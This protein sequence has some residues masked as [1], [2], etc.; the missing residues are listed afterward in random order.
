MVPFRYKLSKG[1]RFYLVNGSN[2]VVSKIPLNIFRVNK[3]TGRLLRLCDGEKTVGEIASSIAGVSEDSVF[4]ICEYFRTKGVLTFEPLEESEYKPYITVII[5]TRDRRDEIKE[6]L[7]YV[8]SQNYPADKI[9]VIVV[10]DGSIDDTLEVLKNYPCQV[11]THKESKG[12]AFCR[13]LGVKRAKGDIV[14]FLDSDCMADKDWLKELVPYFQWS[15]LGAVGGYVAGYFEK[16]SLDR[17]EEA[18]SSLN[19]GNRFLYGADDRS[20]F[21]VPSCNFLVRKKVFLETGGFTEGMKVGEDVDFC[22]RMRALGY[23]LLYAPLGSVKHKHRNNLYQMLKRRAEYG[24]SEAILYTSRSG[25]RKSFY[26]PAFAALTYF[27]LA[28]SIISYHVLPLLVLPGVVGLDIIRKLFRVKKL[29][30][31]IPIRKIAYSVLRSHFLFCYFISFHLVRYYMILIMILGIIFHPLWIFILFSLLLSS[32]VDY[33][34]KRLRLSYP[35]FLMYYT[36]EHSAYQL[37]VF[38]GCIKKRTFKPY[39]PA[40]L[41]KSYQI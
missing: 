8:F 13:N 17:Y 33:A 14:A 24:T 18:F 6:C 41:T 26:I 31:G 12:Q 34:T 37:G 39:I 16:L 36:L 40:F 21:Y 27:L 11:I 1:V 32:I 3:A 29:G 7:D 5:P 22:W 19:M 4:K 9:E 15:P 23:P 2:F 10:D 35:V 38:I 30:I 20:T 28:L 25:K